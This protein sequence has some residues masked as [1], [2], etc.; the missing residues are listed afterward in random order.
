MNAEDCEWDEGKDFP[1]E[2][3][4]IQTTHRKI[5]ETI[6]IEVIRSST[7]EISVFGINYKN[8]PSV[9]WQEV[10]AVVDAGKFPDVDR[11][12]P[13]WPKQE[14]TIPLA[15]YNPLYLADV[16]K[17]LRLRTPC[18]RVLP[19]EKATSSAHVE[20]LGIPREDLIYVLM[21]MRWA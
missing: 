5:E 11:V 14:E 17:E 8:Y 3:F 4:I 9:R 7:K 10:L 13:S 20:F 1:P 18:A 21:P 16:C 6:V 2:N 12:I 19:N 15:A